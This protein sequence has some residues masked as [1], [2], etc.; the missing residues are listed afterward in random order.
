LDKVLSLI[1][2]GFLPWRRDFLLLKRFSLGEGIFYSPQR[3]FSHGERV[4][5]LVKGFFLLER[6]FPLD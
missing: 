3:V 1:G 6:G 2:E 4:F 5:L